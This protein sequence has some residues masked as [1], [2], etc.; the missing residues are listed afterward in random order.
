MPKALQKQT[1]NPNYMG[2]L[3]RVG[4]S[5]NKKVETARFGQNC[6]AT[7]LVRQLRAGW[8]GRRLDGRNAIEKA[9]PT[10]GIP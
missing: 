7:D 4:P 8:A 2:Y 6:R 9:P 3:F 1:P 5:A 10:D